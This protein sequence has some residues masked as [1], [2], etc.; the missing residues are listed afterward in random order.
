MSKIALEALFVRGDIAVAE[1]RS[2]LARAFDLAE[3]VLPRKVVDRSYDVHEAQRELL[4]IAARALGVATAADLA[5]YYGLPAATAAPRIDELVAAL[6]LVPVEVEGWRGPAYRHPDA[7]DPGEVNAQA[8]LAPFDPLIWHRPRVQRLFDFEYRVE[9]F[10]PEL[11]RRWGNYVLPFLY[12]DRLV[13]R[14]DLEADRKKSILEVHAAYL[15]PGADGRDVS[16]ALADELWALAEWLEL[17]DVNVGR[18]GSLVIPLRGA[19]AG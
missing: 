1:R 12:G 16:E 15:E 4:R 10:V 8:L 9:I 11:K 13:G 7:E 18:R 6:D 19:V 14:V 3:R 2:D 5:D 17:E